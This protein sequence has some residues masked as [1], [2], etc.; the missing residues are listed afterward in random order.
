MEWTVWPVLAT[1]AVKRRPPKKMGKAALRS[2]GNLARK[3][4]RERAFDYSV[5]YPA[6]TSKRLI[7]SEALG[8]FA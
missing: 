7:E 6:K 3:A 8:V 5:Y 2:L 4:G 1:L